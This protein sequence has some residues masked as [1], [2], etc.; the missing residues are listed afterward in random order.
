MKHLTALAATLALLACF[1]GA[2][3]AEAVLDA[4]ERLQ[5]QATLAAQGFDPGPADG[6]FGPRT[7]AR[8]LADLDEPVRRFADRAEC[9]GNAYEEAAE[10]AGDCAHEF[11]SEQAECS[12]EFPPGKS[13]RRCIDRA[14]RN[15]DRCYDRSEARYERQLRRC[16]Q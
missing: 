1:A 14:S 8:R 11:L 9:E 7:D 6:K 3:G 12:D 13:R 4:T 16:R 10:K 15:A 2:Q 5:V